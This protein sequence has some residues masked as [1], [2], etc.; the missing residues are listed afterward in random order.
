MSAWG[1]RAVTHSWLVRTSRTGGGLHSEATCIR[2]LVTLKVR[3]ETGD[4]QRHVLWHHIGVIRANIPIHNVRSILSRLPLKTLPALFKNH[5]SFTPY[6]HFKFRP[7]LQF[8]LVCQSWQ[9]HS[10]PPILIIKYQ[11]WRHP[12]DGLSA[13]CEI[14]PMKKK[15]IIIC[16]T[17]ATQ[18]HISDRYRSRSQ[19]VS[20][21]I[22]RGKTDYAILEL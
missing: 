5:I 4:M 3:E 14:C 15:K 16:R 18:T 1:V 21:K 9:H 8:I 10:C 12:A 11:F 17:E 22:L 13:L 20:L 2:A 19:Q 7:F 6:C